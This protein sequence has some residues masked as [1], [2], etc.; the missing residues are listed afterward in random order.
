L[1]DIRKNPLSRKPYFSKKS[2]S[3]ACESVG[4]K[5]K[6]IPE[7]GIVSEKRT[8]LVTLNDY[9]NLFAEYEKT[10][11][12]ESDE[13]LN[14]IVSL[15]DEYE[16]VALTCFEKDSKFCHRGVVAKELSKKPTWNCQ[17]K[18]I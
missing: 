9:R 12:K 17:I 4:I 13:K 5:Y 6:H 2:L 8:T 18:H 16:R 14:D 11:L 7:L 15:M 3:N 10:T 1:C